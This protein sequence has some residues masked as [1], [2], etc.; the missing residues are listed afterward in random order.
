MACGHVASKIRRHR[1]ARLCI[2]SV[3]CT[4]HHHI[5]RL[6]HLLYCSTPSCLAAAAFEL[7]GM[8]IAEPGTCIRFCIM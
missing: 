1:L 8:F 7:P 6:V 4:R 5:C 2:A 3:A